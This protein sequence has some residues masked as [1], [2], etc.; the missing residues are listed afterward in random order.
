MNNIVFLF[1][2]SAR[3]DSFM[4][5]MLKNTQKLGKIE[6]RYSYA[7]WTSPSHYV[8]LMGLLPHKNPTKIFASKVYKK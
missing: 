5:A 6:K 7:S 2:D 3:H 1:I 8:L 4:K